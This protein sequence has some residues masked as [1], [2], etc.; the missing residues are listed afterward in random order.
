MKMEC[1]KKYQ[2]EYFNAQ[3]CWYDPYTNIIGSECI[4]T[5]DME[6]GEKPKCK[7]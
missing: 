5:T 6:G 3:C 4:I 1:A 2:C 7:E